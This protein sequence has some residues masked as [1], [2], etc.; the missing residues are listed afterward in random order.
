MA[1]WFERIQQQR[2]I[3]GQRNQQEAGLQNSVSDL[4]N[5]TT[6]NQQAA[7]DE[8]A[9]G[10][11]ANLDAYN[12]QAIT[13]E[14]AISDWLPVSGAGGGADPYTIPEGYT[15]PTQPTL[16]PAPYLQ[17]PPGYVVPPRQMP[18]PSP[19]RPPGYVVPPRQ[20]RLAQLQ[21]QKRQQWEASQQNQQQ[22]GQ[23]NITSM[24][25][26]IRQMQSR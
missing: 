23:R 12:Q 19:T 2:N 17:R 7:L 8:N 4:Q 6:N 22:L 24:E 15:I 1:S 18:L 13:D 20:D 14:A 3:A 10:D 5:L 25:D 9:V 26:L 11:V 21:L 16:D